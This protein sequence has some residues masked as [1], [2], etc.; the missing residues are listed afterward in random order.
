M[1]R[2]SGVK[3]SRNVFV[4]TLELDVGLAGKNHA[5]EA[6]SYTCAGIRE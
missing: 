6:K 3:Q 2:H 4:P 5:G 1:S